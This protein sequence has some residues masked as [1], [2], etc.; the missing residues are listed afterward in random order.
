MRFLRCI[1]RVSSDLN[2]T[3][4]SQYVMPARLNDEVVNAGRAINFAAQGSGSDPAALTDLDARIQRINEFMA[5]VSSM[6]RPETVDEL[7]SNI[8]A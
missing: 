1:P 5:G 2:A 7:R 4:E 6:T 3:V 8:R